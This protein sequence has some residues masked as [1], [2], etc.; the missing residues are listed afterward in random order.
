MPLSTRSLPP[1]PIHEQLPLTH[2]PD[3]SQLDDIK[4]HLDL[5][6][7]ALEA[8]AGVGSDA[9]LQAAVDL[10]LEAVVSDRVALWRLRQASPLRKGQGRKRLEV[11]EARS[12]V[13]MIS[14]LAQQQVEL[15][16]RSVSLLEQLTEQNRPP[17]HVALL[18]D[19]IDR[20]GNTYEDRMDVQAMPS[21]DEL[22]YL[23]LK[24]LIDL[25]F[26]SAPHGA[27][28]LWV[29]LFERVRP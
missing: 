23:A 29:A 18:G 21:A 25:L 10:G 4:A 24:L 19:Y 15:I 13:L 12:L 6:L 17:H 7:L 1:Q 28:R 2:S 26:Y 5:L 8:L 3:P 16:R 14:H 20:F 27:R 9:M 11:D 22:T